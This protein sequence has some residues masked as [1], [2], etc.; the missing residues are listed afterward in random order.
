MNSCY[1][2]L[3]KCLN[4]I[5]KPFVYTFEKLHVNYIRRNFSLSL[6]RYVS[7]MIN[8]IHYKIKLAIMSIFYLSLKEKKK[9]L[10]R[11]T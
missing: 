1:E 6:Y 7:R 11:L 4:L 10:Y 9:T 5:A 3:Q 2:L 8:V